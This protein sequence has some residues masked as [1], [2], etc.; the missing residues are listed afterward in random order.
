MKFNSSH[1]AKFSLDLGGLIDLRM[2][3]FEP[4]PAPKTKKGLKA[5]RR[6]ELQNTVEE[7]RKVSLGDKVK[8][9]C[10]NQFFYIK[11]WKTKEQQHCMS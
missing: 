10:I 6:G 4:F 1:I 11:I 9:K 2:A 5:E 3:T 8:H 7:R